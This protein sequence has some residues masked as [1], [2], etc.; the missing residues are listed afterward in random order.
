MK[1]FSKQF[2]KMQSGA[3]AILSVV[4]AGLFFAPTDSFAGVSEPDTIFYGKI[5]NR[6]GGAEYMLTKG[7]LVWKISRP[8]GQQIT[9]NAPVVSVGG[10]IYSY[11]L[12]VPQEALAFG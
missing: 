9:L 8:D 6:T 12:L 2:L 10:G 7:N 11:Q 3:F 1:N 4:A 5:I